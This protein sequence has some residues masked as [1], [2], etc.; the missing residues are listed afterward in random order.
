MHPICGTQKKKRT[1]SRHGFLLKFITSARIWRRRTVLSS[2]K[3]SPLSTLGLEKY[4]STEL[5]VEYKNRRLLLKRAVLEEHRWQRSVQIPHPERLASISAKNSRWARERARAA[6][7]FLEHDVMQD[8]EE[9][10]RQ[11]PRPRCGSNPHHDMMSS[12]DEEQTCK[13]QS[14]QRGCGILEPPPQSKDIAHQSQVSKFL[15][16]RASQ[17]P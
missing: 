17:P 8:V 7:L 15:E 5:T 10:L 1:S 14:Y 2:M 12:R 11:P 3:N 16:H 4:L 6:A 13:K 9:V